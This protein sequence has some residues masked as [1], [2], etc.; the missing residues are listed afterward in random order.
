MREPR[1]AEERGDRGSVEVTTPTRPLTRVERDGRQAAGSS[2]H[3]RDPE[4]GDGDDDSETYEECRTDQ[5]TGPVGEHAVAREQQVHS[6][7]QC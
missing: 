3:P 5:V 6:S 4:P 1:V 2:R 7:T